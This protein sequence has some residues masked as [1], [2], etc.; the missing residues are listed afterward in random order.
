MNADEMTQP[1]AVATVGTRHNKR[2]WVYP[3]LLIESQRRTAGP[4]GG[5]AE[6]AVQGPVS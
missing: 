6:N 2:P 5:G 3:V 1:E 4:K